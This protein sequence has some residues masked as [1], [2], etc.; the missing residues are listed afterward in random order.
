MSKKLLI[1]LWT[2]FLLYLCPCHNLYASSEQSCD[3]C[4]I[5]EQGTS[6]EKVSLTTDST[7]TKKT[8]KIKE[9]TV[10][11]Y[12]ELVKAIGSNRKIKLVPG[13]YNPKDFHMEEDVAIKN[14]KNLTL[15]GIP[16]KGSNYVDLSA[17][18]GNFLFTNC[19]NIKIENLHFKGNISLEESSDLSMT[20]C[21]VESKNMCA[22][23]MKKVTNFTCTNS[24]IQSSFDQD[25]LYIDACTKVW[26]DHCQLKGYT[27][28][29]YDYEAMST[30]IMFKDCALINNAGICSTYSNY[31]PIK[32]DCGYEVFIGTEDWNE[33]RFL[34]AIKYSNHDNEYLSY[35]NTYDGNEEIYGDGKFLKLAEHLNSLMKGKAF[36]SIDYVAGDDP[37]YNAYFDFYGTPK[38]KKLNINLC[39]ANLS[40][41]NQETMCKMIKQLEPLKAEILAYQWPISI[42]YRQENR[43]IIAVADFSNES[44]QEYMESEDDTQLTMYCTVMYLGAF[45][46]DYSS[47]VSINDFFGVTAIMDKKQVLQTIE[48]H[49][50]TKTLKIKPNDDYGQRNSIAYT[51]NNQEGLFL[52]STIESF[53]G[54]GD[55]MHY[56]TDLIVATNAMNGKQSILTKNKSYDLVD[57]EVAKVNEKYRKIIFKE[58]GSNKTIKKKI[59]G[60]P[61][62]DVLLFIDTG[63]EGDSKKFVFLTAKHC[64]DAGYY[65]EYEFNYYIGTLNT[66]SNKVTSASS[67]E[68]IDFEKLIYN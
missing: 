12:K 39:V 62:K 48:K 59:I 38:N 2:A 46:E 21:F 19:S 22:I 54:Q 23:S 47:E 34:A 16:K 60:N 1:L 67:M 50:L 53:S 42:V 15:I 14:V 44:F 3:N 57:A 65:S 33:T 13:N 29:I 27:V 32:N 10:S 20:K 6:I 66:K 24:S 9:I 18:T 40:D 26:F 7:T 64:A 41:A 37:N 8:T 17:S 55:F 4:N 30:G 63:K 68:L 58:L 56:T 36:L 52:L 25:I 61:C 45:S 49:F 43:T 11:N 51:I 5:Q 35:V 28:N 31:V